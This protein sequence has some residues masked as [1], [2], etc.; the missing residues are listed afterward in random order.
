[1]TT[2]A[3]PPSNSIRGEQLR[4]YLPPWLSRNLPDDLQTMPSPEL[5][6]VDNHLRQLL[7][8]M[9]TY[10]PRQVVNEVLADPTPGRV[11]GQTTF[12]TLL[13]ADI[14][15]F[16]ALSEHIARLGREGA[17]EITGIVNHYFTH[18]IE[19]SDRECGFL[20][21]FAGDAMILLFT[22]EDHAWRAVRAGVAMQE[23]MKRFAHVQTS[24]G[25]FSLRVKMGIST[26]DIFTAHVGTR[27]RME[28]VV[29]GQAVRAMAQAENIA[30]AGEL[31]LNEATFQ[32]VASATRDV[33]PRDGF[34]PLRPSSLDIA[35]RPPVPAG[36]P[37]MPEPAKPLP[38]HVPDEIGVLVH[39]IET[40]APYLPYGLLDRLIVD[41]LNPQMAGEHRLVT[42][43][44]ADVVSWNPI[45]SALI[46]Q[47]PQ[48]LTNIF[49][50]YFTSVHQIVH[51]YGGVVNK[52]DPSLHGHRLMA[53]F[54]AP[55]AHEDDAERAVLSALE[56]E[57]ALA[58]TNQAIRT[59]WEQ[60]NIPGT[61]PPPL[62]QQIGIN[63]G[64]VFASNV[65]DRHRQ[66]YSIMGDEV[67]L[68]ARLIGVTKDNQIL[69]SAA[70]YHKLADQFVVREQP[71]VRVKGKALPVQTYQVL[72]AQ[73]ET[74]RVVHQTTLVGRT[75]EL[76]A[77][78]STLERVEHGEGQM[79]AIAGDVG[80]G[81][82][83]L[84]DALYEAAEHRDFAVLHATC[85][86]YGQNVPYLPW[87]T[88]LRA[89]IGL[90][91]AD[92]SDQ[93]IAKVYDTL[94]DL[95]PAWQELAPLLNPFVGLNL[96]ENDFTRHLDA[97]TRR[98]RLFDLILHLLQ[99]AAT[100]S[101]LLLA[102]DDLQWLDST[103][104]DLIQYIARNI[105][106]H[107]ILIAV[108]Y[109]TESA[110]EVWDQFAPCKKLIVTDLPAGDSLSLVSSMLGTSVVPAPLEHL[111]MERTQGNP[112][113]LEEIVRALVDRKAL[114]IDEEGQGHLNPDW[115]DIDVPDTIHGMVISRID[116]LPEADRRV[117]QVA[118]V[119]GQT[120][121][122]DVLRGVFPHASRRA[123]IVDRLHKMSTRGLTLLDHPDPDM[124]YAFKHT[125]IQEVTYESLPFAR[126]R[127]LHA[128]VAR[129]VEETYA[130]NL[131]ERYD[132]LAHHYYLGRVWPK[133][134]DYAIKAGERAQAA[135]AN[136]AAITYY[137]RALELIRRHQAA[138][139]AVAITT[140]EALGDVYHLTGQY[141]AASEVYRFALEHEE[142]S[143]ASCAELHRKVARV[144]QF[145]ADYDQALAELDRAEEA[146]GQTHDPLV[147][148]RIGN[149][150]GW[151]FARQGQYEEAEAA[152]DQALQMLAQVQPSEDSRR[153][154][155]RIYDN[156]GSIC[157]F[158]GEHDR[159]IAYL[160][161]S[162][163]LKE[164]LGDQQGVAI[165]YNRIAAVHWS[166]GDYA[167]AAE[168]MK[169]SLEIRE[170]IGDRWGAATA[171]N[172]LGIVYYTQGRYEQA[173][174]CY[175][176]AL[177]TWQEV[178]AASGVAFCHVNLGELYFSDGKLDEASRHLEQGERWLS[179]LGE[180][181]SLFDTRKWLA[182]V[183][184][185]QGCWE[186][187][188]Q[189]AQ[190]IVDTAK[191]TGNPETEGIA[192]RIL[193]Q[194]LASGTD[195]GWP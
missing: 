172:N 192:Q 140:A 168:Y 43:L 119:I 193:G 175:Q 131:L 188:K 137:E 17:E 170:R 69:V 135:Y 182:Q 47:A 171:Y 102:I 38:S 36:A 141:D 13:M 104:R 108:A 124:A 177:N 23:A 61:L 120:F 161:D 10:L 167:S 97:K 60:T 186:E 56:M 178:G 128:Q 130:A 111:I 95:E 162:L 19:S 64:F 149:D 113:F 114:Y 78:R 75:S 93:R 89:Y 107:R 185:A 76:E 156:L 181:G 160:Q 2:S 66:E 158:T 16:T 81:K 41:P 195:T 155:T 194:V 136:E 94:K 123:E 53:L 30:Q 71:A 63:T 33:S 179:E 57:E 100:Q 68:A 147:L 101:P 82:T 22:D 112:F 125:M 3:P 153:V 1:M 14:T 39:K 159:S 32:V 150:R 163:T 15:G 98:Q 86:S 24:Q 42:A 90:S 58:K 115:E 173:E 6:Q 132:F 54:G 151:V 27:E 11:R 118:S 35:A 96:P 106:T 26:G 18:M 34:Y 46:H 184:L 174:A 121:P 49:N 191:E 83:R 48:M 37:A 51:R 73:R 31:V 67:N 52:V 8:T 109:R 110:T 166:R 134:T 72:G 62:Y 154:R 116:R 55:I 65:G 25:E 99:Q 169:R 87:T 183:R 79:M 187:A 144:R 180:Q 91:E 117:L 127:Y 145:Q 122:V 59:T 139:P 129:F 5:A 70:T 84:L 40:L 133:A 74:T 164:D 92:T 12:G 44:F 152:C 28:Y 105:A 138:P 20:I 189:Y 176:Q 29:M 142:L 21:K 50:T 77:L 103:S 4:P 143:P 9:A 126:R 45:V 148:A 157:R 85:L 146:L 80:V 165:V 7:Q 190:M 88:L